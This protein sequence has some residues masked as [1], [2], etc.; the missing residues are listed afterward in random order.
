[1]KTLVFNTIPIVS[2]SK[3]S[4]KSYLI[5]RMHTA[6]PFLPVVTFNITMINCHSKELL[7]W[8][9]KRALFTPDGIGVCIAMFLQHFKWVKR[10]AGIDMVTGILKQSRSTLRVALIGS[11]SDVVAAASS[12]VTS[13]GHTVVFERD[14]YSHFEETDFN[15][16]KDQQPQLVL[17]AKGAPKQ[18]AFMFELANYLQTGV[19]IGVGG[20]FDVWAG[21]TKRAPYIWRIIGMEWLY[22]ALKEPVR[23]RRIVSGIL[24]LFK[25]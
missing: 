6:K 15:S 4:I 12:F 19:A 9:K 22:R 13:L 11:T 24:A 17:V 5:N 20:S 18:E 7:V 14:G 2:E 8:L 3:A 23:F 16:L 10:Y 21:R 1:M 25:G